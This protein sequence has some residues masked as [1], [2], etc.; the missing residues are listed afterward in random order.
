MRAPRAAGVVEVLEDERAARPRRTRSR[1]GGRRRGGRCPARQ[2]RHVAEGGQADPDHGGLGAAPDGDVAPARGHEPAGGGDGVGAGR[3]R[4]GD[5]LARAVPPGVHRDVAA[6]ALDHHHR[7][8]EA[9][10][11]G[12]APS[13]GRPRSGPGASRGRP[14]RW[15]RRRRSG[16]GR[17]RSRRRRRAPCRR[18]PPRTGRSGRPGGPLSGRTTGRGVEARDPTLTLGR[19]PLQAV[20]EGVEADPA[21]RDDAH[22]GDGDPPPWTG[23]SGPMPS[24]IRAWRRSARR[25]GR[26]SRCPRARS[27]RR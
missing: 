21:A 15:R 14:R 3:A 20:P 6:P 11:P 9:A 1:P 24:S 2:R 17:R 4:G 25:P 5:G 27:R 7:D 23:P 18:R 13:R 16:R 12:A 26:R 22:A 19:G 10:T 8:Q